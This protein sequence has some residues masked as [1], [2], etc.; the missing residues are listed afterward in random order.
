[1]SKNVWV[2]SFDQV[3]HVGHGSQD[4]VWSQLRGVL[5][6]LVDTDSPKP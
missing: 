3:F 4:V 5:G 1:M 6:D 2:V